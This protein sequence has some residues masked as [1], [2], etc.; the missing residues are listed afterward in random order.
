MFHSVRGDVEAAT[1]SNNAYLTINRLGVADRS[2]Y[3]KYQRSGRFWTIN[4][5]ALQT[6]FFIAFGRIFDNRSDSF[7][8]Q[9]LVEATIANPALFSKTAL[10]ER[11]RRISHITGADPKWLVDFVGQVWEPTASDL[12]PLRTALAPHLDKFKAI[13]RPIR[14]KY[15]AHRGTESQQAIEALFG[16]TLKTD[17]AEILGFLHTVLWAIREMAL[18]GQRLD[19]TDFA[20]YDGEV[21]SVNGD[22][23]KFIRE[24]P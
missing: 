23:E 17:V 6:T 9:K 22:I 7:S 11:K 20:D 10:L 15:F 14:H 13:Y 19:L 21:N 16:K 12:E 2:I 8:I 18:N 3:D 5:Y 1:A 4:T 24:L